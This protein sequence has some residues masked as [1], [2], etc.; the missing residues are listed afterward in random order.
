MLLNICKSGDETVVLLNPSDRPAFTAEEWENP[1][2]RVPQ[3]L[4]LW[5]VQPVRLHLT[6]ATTFRLGTSDLSSDSP[7]QCGLECHSGS[8]GLCGVLHQSP[9]PFR[10]LQMAN[11]TLVP[12]L[13]SPVYI[14]L[15]GG[16]TVCCCV[17]GLGVYC[18]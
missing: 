4:G 15:A 6:L 2:W 13:W 11:G 1:K 3:M 16:G 17:W 14:C 7:V 8:R 18:W 12:F 5:Q 9:W 10:P